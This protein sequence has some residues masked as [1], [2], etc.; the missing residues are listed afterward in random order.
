MI[1]SKD[2]WTDLYVGS[3]D[4]GK[5]NRLTRTPQ[6]ESSPC[7]SPK[8]DWICYAA[9]DGER[10]SLKKISPSGGQS[11]RI[12]TG[13]FPSPSEPD[14]SPD[15]NWIA[16]TSQTRSFQ[17]CVVKANGGEPTALVEGEDPSWAPNSRTLIYGRRQGGHYVLAL[18]DVPTKQTRDIGRIPEINSQSQ[19]S[20][21][22]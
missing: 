8:G 12:N 1:L 10:R 19:P 2:G 4:G 15:G 16:F 22:R 21:A 14:W 20:W 5:P 3:A 11:Q 13:G 17:I 18:L 9:K 7:W 6:D